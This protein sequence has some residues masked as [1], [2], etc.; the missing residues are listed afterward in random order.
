M[1]YKVARG[2]ER[3]NRIKEFKV[4]LDSKGLK[5]HMLKSGQKEL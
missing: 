1:V 3:V 5:K 4:V 2:T